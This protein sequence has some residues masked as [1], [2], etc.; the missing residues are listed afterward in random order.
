M[1]EIQEQPDV[2][3][4]ELHWEAIFLFTFEIF[5]ESLEK[6]HGLG[7][8]FWESG[9]RKG[10][11]KRL[12]EVAAEGMVVEGWRGKGWLDFVGGIEETGEKK[13]SLEQLIVKEGAD[14]EGQQDDAVYLEEAVRVQFLVELLPKRL[15]LWQ[16]TGGFL[17]EGIH[18]GEALV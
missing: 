16:L 10:L 6:D 13:D 12:F 4:I 1:V 5:L 3:N 8:I 17:E 15:L 9:V 2:G 7:D 11:Q 18:F 14:S